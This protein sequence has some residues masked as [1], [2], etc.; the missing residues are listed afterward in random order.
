MMTLW[1]R[2]GRDPRVKSAVTVM[3][4]PPEHN[5]VPLTPAEVGTL[6]DEK[7][8]ARDITSTIVGL[9]VKGYIKIEETVKEGLLFD[10]TDYYL[11]K[12]KERD[13]HLSPFEAELMKSLFSEAQPGIHISD[14][15][16]KF[17]KNLP[18][19]K[20]TLYGELIREKN[21]F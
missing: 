1:Y 8:D 18:S 4:Q 9:A 6:I 15:K 3:Y 14:L 21:I 7:I 2:R 10:S 19:L 17:Y 16:N 5:N 11:S 12:V 20:D 13:A